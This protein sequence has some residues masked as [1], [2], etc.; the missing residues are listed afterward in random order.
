MTTNGPSSWD[1]IPAIVSFPDTARF[2]ET[3]GFAGTS[4][5]VNLEGQ[6]LRTRDRPSAT[7]YL[8]MHP[9]STLQLLQMPAALS[10]ACLHLLCAASRYAKN[11]ND[12]NMEK[13]VIAMEAWDV[14]EITEERRL[15]KEWDR[16]DRH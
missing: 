15:W 6:L 16:K 7:V 8:F 2:T 1:R 4:G 5:T 9:T 11:D 10:A 3:Y 12:L 13:V 14:Q